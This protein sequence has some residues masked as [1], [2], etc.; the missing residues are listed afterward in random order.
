MKTMF[1]LFGFVLILMFCAIVLRAEG[2]RSAEI[3]AIG[4]YGEVTVSTHQWTAVPSTASIDI[5]RIGI[6]LDEYNTNSGNMLVFVST[7]SS[8]P[9]TVAISTGLTMTP[10]DAPW[11]LSIPYTL[12]VWMRSL[13]ATAE[14]VFYMELK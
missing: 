5:S 11:Q 2:G 6:W 13:N 10:N 4:Q 7:W 12:K 1:R 8:V 3:Q 14:K 9:A